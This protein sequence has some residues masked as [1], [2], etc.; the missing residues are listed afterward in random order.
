MAD[1][2]RVRYGDFVASQRSP[3]SSRFRLRMQEAFRWSGELGSFRAFLAAPRALI[4]SL[5]PFEAARQLVKSEGIASF[6]KQTG[7]TT[8][9]ERDQESARCGE[10]AIDTH[11]RR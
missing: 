3:S 1:F 2:V 9:V 8:I 6:V 10:S 11:R 5:D 7:G 4:A